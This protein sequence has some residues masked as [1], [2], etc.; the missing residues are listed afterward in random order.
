MLQT[1]VLEKK[2]HKAA[3]DVFGELLSIEFDLAPGEP[4][5]GW[6][7]TL[8]RGVFEQ[9]FALYHPF[10]ELHIQRNDTGKIIAFTDPGRLNPDP[11]PSPQP[12]SA[13]ESLSIAA[14]TG[15]LGS[16]AQVESLSPMPGNLI[17]ARIDIN[18]DGSHVL[19]FILNP[20]EMHV[21]AFA[22]VEDT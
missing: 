18:G 19:D 17:Q 1:S 21:A 11:P 13:E 10:G 22:P 9:S 15:L 8:Q 6:R 4:D 12:L 2:A 5:E 7:P 16:G 3:K 14:T 20:A